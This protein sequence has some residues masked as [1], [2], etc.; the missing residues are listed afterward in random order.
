MIIGTNS[1][2]NTTTYTQ[3]SRDGAKKTNLAIAEQQSFK[4]TENVK[5]L[6]ILKDL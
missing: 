6:L 4:K 1:Y 3:S 2:Y 5:K